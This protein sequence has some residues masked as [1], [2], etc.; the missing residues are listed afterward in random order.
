MNVYP[1]PSSNGVIAIETIEDLQ[2]ADITI[3]TLAG[4]TVYS[5]KVASFSE[6]KVINVQGLT[7]GQYI[8][9][10][11]SQGF[12]VARRVLVVP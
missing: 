4:Q 1:N 12:N 2:N 9:R 7:A 8:V 3:A 6:R 11:R 5:A 10:V